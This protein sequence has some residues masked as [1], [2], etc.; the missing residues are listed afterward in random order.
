MTST[1]PP[2][3]LADGCLGR[4]PPRPPTC[5]PLSA[6]KQKL[7]YSPTISPSFGI[8]KMSTIQQLTTPTFSQ[9]DILPHLLLPF[10]LIGG[11]FL[12]PFRGRA[13]V[14]LALLTLIQWR[15][16]VSSWPPNTGD[17]RA[18]RYGLAT[19]WIFVLP[20]VERLVMHTP[21]RDIWRV[22]EDEENDDEK[23]GPKNE[24]KPNAV[25]TSL[26]TSTSTLKRGAPRTTVPDPNV[27]AEKLQAR[28][29]E[30]GT[31]MTNKPQIPEWSSAKLL[32]ALHLIA[33]PR[34]VGYNISGRSV[35]TARARLWKAQK[36]GVLTRTRFVTQKFLTSAVCYVV[37]DAI[38]V[39]WQRV[40]AVPDAW[41][42][43]SK[44]LREI[45][46]AEVLMLGTV[47]CGMTMQFENAAGIA[48]GLGLSKIEVSVAFF[49]FGF[50]FTYVDKSISEF[51]LT[52]ETVG[53]AS[54][55]W[56]YPGLL[57]RSKRMGDILASV[58]STGQLPR[59]SHPHHQAVKLTQSQSSHA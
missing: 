40:A 20:V 7:T 6:C 25:S 11:Y 50:L 12:P 36:T 35:T 4:K 16:A 46:V 24:L 22:N 31:T 55:L 17:T 47:Y 26:L 8:S 27:T 2:Q 51:W 52:M 48:V 37:W 41:E 32:F 14:F 15:C 42:W 58:Y 21:E 39:V 9:I 33:S 59:Y 18:M 5:R 3:P 45:G 53:L 44:T 54:C 43:D 56:K 23:S 34:A 30:G 49:P 28:A 13:A 38:M 57:H 10:L 29:P 19:S 1:T